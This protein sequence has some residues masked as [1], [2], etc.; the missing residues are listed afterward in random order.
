MVTQPLHHHRQLV[1]DWFVGCTFVFVKQLASFSFSVVKSSRLDIFC[2]FFLYSTDGRFHV[3]TPKVF[4]I[5]RYG[6]EN[7]KV[8]RNQSFKGAGFRG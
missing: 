3:K 1:N 6:S 5:I 2:E 7:S 4:Q 8:S